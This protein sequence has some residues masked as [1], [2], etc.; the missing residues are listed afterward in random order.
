M[1]ILTLP[2]AGKPATNSAPRMRFAVAGFMLLLSLIVGGKTVAAQS[3]STPL[4]Y[5]VGDN[6]NGGTSGDF[7]GDNKPDLAI[8][9]VLS[10]NV[11]VLLNKGDGTFDNAVYYAT[12]F[13]PESVVAADLNNDGKLDLA[14]G[15]FLGGATSSGNISILL[16]NGNGT[17]QTAV[18][19]AAS[20]PIK[21]KAV[22][23]NG[24][25]KLDLAAASWNANSASV[26]LGNGDGTFQAATTYS[27]GTQPQGIAVADFNADGKPDLAVTNIASNNVSILLGNGNGTFQTGLDSS[28][29]SGPTGIAASDL[30][31]DGKQ[32][33]VVA[34][35]HSNA[36][37]LLRGNGNGSFQNPV[38]YAVGAEPQRIELADFNGD[39]LTDV[40]VVNA[41]SNSF[42]V[43]R[44]NG[45][46]TFQS[47][48][49]QASRNGSFSPIVND[50][51]VDGKPDLAILSNSLD[52][53]DVRLNSP[54]ARGVAIS[55]VAAAPATGVLVATFKDYDA[56]KTAGSFTATID[57]GDTATTAGTISA[58]G[59]GGF[60]VN[61][62][63]TYAREGTFNVLVSIA[64]MNGNFARATSTAIVADAPLTA[65]GKPISATRG[66]AFSSLVAT[67]TD[68]DPTGNVTEFS[69]TINWGDGTNSAGIITANGSGGF[70]VT[71]SH[72]YA[73][74]GSL[75]VVVTIQDVGGSSATANS[76][77][78]VFDP[79]GGV[80]V[81]SSADYNVPEIAGSILLIVNRSGDTTKAVAVDYVTTD[82]TADGRKDYIPTR[83]T[84]RFEAGQT[85][86]ALPVLV[87]V[88]AFTEGSEFVQVALSNPTGGAVLGSPATTTLR[89]DNTP[90]TA[91]PANP[92]DSA[93]A[94]VRQHYHDFLN[95]DAGNDPDGLNFWTNQI[96]ECQQPGATCNAEVRRINVSA[97][98]FLSIEF[99]ETG[100]L[101]ERLYKVAYG[102][103]SGTSNLGP[104][105][106]LAVPIV[107]LEEFLPDSQEI[108]RG[109]VVGQ[110]GWE[111][112]LENNKIA[113]ILQFEQRSRFTTAFPTSLTPDQFVDKLFTNAGVTPATAER[114]SIISEFGGAVTSADNA[115][116]GRALRRVAENATL[117]QAEKKKAFVLM[118]FFGYLRRNPNDPQ[119]TDYTGYDFWLSKLNEFSGDFIRAEMVKAFLDSTEYR[120]RFG[121]N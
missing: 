13:N 97:A 71:G 103:A 31:G 7:N 104:T 110:T 55:A 51:D 65:T 82:L 1:S 109:L 90:W 11:S 46:G 37:L 53:V 87:N 35:V 17:F 102:D 41:N 86:K 40:V 34:A 113:F 89:I 36:V 114:T 30:D 45:N 91:P 112:V 4:T 94:F 20:S 72:T 29:P 14:V 22:D 77:A 15:N 81:F 5:S 44:G 38:S 105:H 75:S 68:A 118:Q 48:I 85:S 59:S 62:T 66:I 43:L 92:L 28:T 19:Y 6:P 79:P 8:G 119:D 12:D 26:L 10:R 73:I 117:N 107:R 93:G 64:D 39:A 99:Q 21:L 58:N 84:L 50:F 106:Q 16:G 100:Y 116:R 74:G 24:D 88:D 96:T 9:N 3:F 54:S 56:S 80:I 69:A 27:A 61:G 25:G 115:A 18:N 67:F 49:T 98:F 95:R 2:L 63:H 23:L 33:L 121:P 32:D 42:S 47:A 111:Q 70:D 120:A 108:G 101:V 76:T 83:G 52:V 78:N 57:W 60:N